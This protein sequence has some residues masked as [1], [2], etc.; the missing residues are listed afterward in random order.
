MSFSRVLLGLGLCQLLS[1]LVRLREAPG[2]SDLVYRRSRRQR[3]LELSFVACGRIVH[4][5]LRFVHGTK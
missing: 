4:S 3:Q 1:L 5:K 2:T